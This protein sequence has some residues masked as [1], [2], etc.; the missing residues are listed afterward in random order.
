[1]DWRRIAHAATARL[2][3]A[4]HSMME[5]TTEAFLSRD[6][7]PHTRVLLVAPKLGSRHG[8]APTGEPAAQSRP[9]QRF[10]RVPRPWDVRNL[11]GFEVAGSVPRGYELMR[12]GECSVLPDWFPTF[13]ARAPEPID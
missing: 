12:C 2:M 9:A 8:E 5:S 11:V 13:E 6:Q 3:M 1:M 7:L 10:N 4:N